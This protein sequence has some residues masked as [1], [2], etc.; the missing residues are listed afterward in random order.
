MKNPAALLLP[1]AFFAAM[2]AAKRMAPST[3]PAPADDLTEPRVVRSESARAPEWVEI[4]RRGDRGTPGRP[5]ATRPGPA[6]PW[7]DASGI[8]ALAR[9]QAH[10]D[11]LH[12]RPEPRLAAMSTDELIDSLPPEYRE[13]ARRYRREL[14]TFE[15]RF[16]RY[17]CWAP[18]TPRA[19]VEAYRRIE[20]E[21]GLAPGEARIQA[22]QFDLG[23]HWSRTATNSTGNSVQGLPVTLTWSIA[24]DGTQAPDHNNNDG[25][26]NLRA[27]LVGIF[28]GGTT[29]DLTQQPW[30]TPLQEA[31]DRIGAQNGITFVYE[32]ND[33]GADFGGSAS[34][35]ILGTRGDIRLMARPMDGDYGTLA[36][37]YFPDW[38]DMVIDSSD[39]YFDN[40]DNNPEGL[41]NVI[42]HELGH[43]LGLDHVCP[44]NQ[45]KLMEPYV[46][47]SFSGPQFDD[48]YSLQRLYG[49]ELE[50]HS[51]A[52]NNDSAADATPLALVPGSQ[53]IGWLSI[54]DDSDVDYLRFT[55]PAGRQVTLRAIPSDPVGGTY[56]EGEQLSNGS[57][58][59]GS[60]FDPRNRQDLTLE[61]LDA[62]GSTVLA[63]SVSGGPAQ[64]EEILDHVLPSAGDFLIRIDGGSNDSAQ[65]YEL[66]AELE[67]APNA[68]YLAITSQT[69]VDESNLP[70]NGLADPGETIRLEVVVDNVGTLA[71]DSVDASLS[72]P[73]GFTGFEVSES[74]ASIA[75]S[76]SHTFSFV[77]AQ[78]GLCT[79]EVTLD[80]T[81][82]ASGGHDFS[83]T[84]ELEL[85]RIVSVAALLEGFEGS[86]TLPAGWSGTT[87]G[88]GSG[89]GVSFGNADDG[90]RAATAD[91]VAGI[92]ESL[93]SS[94]VATL[95]PD[96]T[97][98]FRHQFDFEAGYDGA[99]L[100]YSR[101]G[102]AWADLL[103]PLPA[104]VVVLEGGYNDD[105]S[106]NYNSPIAGR[107]A[108]SGSSSG[109]DTVRIQFPAAWEGDDLQ[110][111][112]ILATDES[113]AENDWRIDSILLA[114]EQPGCT[115]FR[116]AL[117][118]ATTASEVGE[119]GSI[120]ATLSTPLPLAEAVACTLETGGDAGASDLG[121]PLSLV[122]PAGATS[123]E[124]PVAALDDG[125]SEGT[126]SL[127]LSVP[128]SAPG[129]AAVAPA[130]ITLDITESLSGYALWSSGYPGLDP[131]PAV[132]NDGDGWSALAEYLFDTSPDDPASRPQI[133]TVLEATKLRLVLPALPSRPDATLTGETST[134]LSGWT[135]TGV[136]TE[137]DGFSVPRGDPK[138]FLRLRF[139]L[140]AP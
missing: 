15:D 78:D 86:A 108:W 115:D 48:I 54:D 46:T 7:I 44:I 126:E 61:L 71:A 73:A 36:F 69:L 13:R 95:G 96:A 137:P 100:E 140:Q 49:D 43:S 12:R 118:L 93:L 123:L 28:G 111:R 66:E 132:D 30:F 2:F 106:N 35:G 125:L 77:F 52:R 3:G 135:P 74:V 56:L 139:S 63:Q 81:L 85:G 97:L 102:G 117:S 16:R 45:T 119:G 8:E 62:T 112:W 4:P 47:T 98:S 89:W 40:A 92:G 128:G 131:D 27:W 5:T 6:E 20:I 90:D 122:L 25:P 76:G 104:G 133:T 72:G 37:A 23:D 129:Y 136:T 29:G 41:L 24:P 116:P 138:R 120:T 1:M 31:I 103:D 75:S 121:S 113:V 42:T 101:N 94:P 70:N 14:G 32:P 21:G 34:R 134:D 105:I 88:S 99:V 83:T 10:H 124:F 9:A 64:S 60:A 17:I 55:V 19:V 51:P 53:T 87:S 26:S 91:S 50:T 130:S 80:L 65:L 58:S 18:G 114:S 59:S 67:T 109:Y 39:G 57:C 22:T 38:G 84:L 11:A 110:L 33:D 79:D 127:T 82:T 107:D 68:P